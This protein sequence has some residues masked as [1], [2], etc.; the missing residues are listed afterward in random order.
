MGV[1]PEALTQREAFQFTAAIK[2]SQEEKGWG[3]LRMRLEGGAVPAIGDYATV[4]WA[5][6]K[7]IGDEVE[8]TDEMGRP[9]R[10]RIVG[11][12]A[13]SVLQGSLVIAE[14]EF[15]ARFPSVDGYRVLLVDAAPDKVDAV[16]QKLSSGLRDYGLVLTP[17][18]ERLAAFGA[19]EDTYL[20][21]FT[22]LGGLGLVLGSVGLGMVVLRN[23]LERRGELAMLRAVGFGRGRLK[24]MVFYEHWGLMLAGLT[25]GVISAVVAVIPAVHSPGGQV[26]Y[27]SLLVTVAGIAI[28]GS[29]LG[30]ARR[31]VGSAWR[32]LDALRHE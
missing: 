11:M 12:L 19:V 15:V 5:L 30:V 10:V 13:N 17:T 21:I 31:D 6:G 14:N 7:N 28:S 25:C 26:P 20:S 8:Y 3:L 27:V 4:F 16:A 18:Q 22:V 32:L 1:Q 23:M 24:R 9:F 29:R 2:E